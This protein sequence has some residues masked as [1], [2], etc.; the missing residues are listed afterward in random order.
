MPCEWGCEEEERGQG[1]GFPWTWWLSKS[2]TSCLLTAP[3]VRPKRAT[4]PSDTTTTGTVSPRCPPG[5][6]FSPGDMNPTDT[7]HAAR[8]T[9]LVSFKASPL[10]HGVLAPSDLPT[11]CRGDC[12]S[13]RRSHPTSWP[14]CAQPWDLLTHKDHGSP[15]CS[16]GLAHKAFCDLVPTYPSH[17]VSPSKSRG[18]S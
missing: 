11:A 15:R 9:S 5:L 13:P 1:A 4:G 8:T 3:G 10:L 18:T 17:F 12:R 2:S 6:L 14:L 16:W 7:Y